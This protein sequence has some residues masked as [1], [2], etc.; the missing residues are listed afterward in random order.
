MAAEVGTA[1]GHTVDRAAAGPRDFV[2]DLPD[3][4]DGKDPSPRLA[5]TAWVIPK[6]LALLPMQSLT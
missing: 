3:S 5:A 1:T 4:P 6:P 2:A